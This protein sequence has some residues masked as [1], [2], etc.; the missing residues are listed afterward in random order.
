MIVLPDLTIEQLLL[1]HTKISDELRSRGVVRS[2]NNPTGDLAEYL[3]CRAFGWDQAPNSEKSFDACD[4]AGLRIQIKARRLHRRNSSRQLSAIRDLNGF[5]VLA[6]LLF[7]ETYQVIR[8]VLIP[9]ATVRERSTYIAHTNSHKFYL[10]DGVFALPGVVDVTDRI[11]AIRS[12]PPS[13]GDQ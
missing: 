8:A 12:A 4:E 5:D 1:L 7:D 13:V 6:G 9:A 3:F 11:L 2:A 10:R